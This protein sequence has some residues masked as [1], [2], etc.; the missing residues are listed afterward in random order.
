MD[1]LYILTGSLQG[2]VVELI[3]EDITVGRSPDNSICFD[4]ESVSE[5]HA[6]ITRQDHDYVVNDLGSSRGTYVRGERI[7]IAALQDA[8]KVTFESVE[9]Q[10]ETAEVKLHLPTTPIIPAPTVPIP[11]HNVVSRHRCDSGGEAIQPASRRG[12]SKLLQL[13]VLVIAIA[14]GW[15]IYEKL[16]SSVPESGSTPTPSVKQEARIPAQTQPAGHR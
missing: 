15:W 6:T 3:G 9:A 13:A 5:H 7:I 12:M 8:D 10:L 14:F 2:A 1:K 16:G 4:D 11:T